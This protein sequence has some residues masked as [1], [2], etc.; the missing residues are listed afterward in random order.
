MLIFVALTE[1]LNKPESLSVAEGIRKIELD[2]AQDDL[3]TAARLPD[4]AV[5]PEASMRENSF[6]PRKKQPKKQES[7]SMP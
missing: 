1:A 6:A 3:F 5:E 4:Y 2:R 7:D